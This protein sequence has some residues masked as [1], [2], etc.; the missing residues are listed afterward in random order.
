MQNT[1]VPGM[2]RLSVNSDICI[3]PLCFTCLRDHVTFHPT[4]DAVL[5]PS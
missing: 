4:Q 5:S 1:G 3:C 2:R